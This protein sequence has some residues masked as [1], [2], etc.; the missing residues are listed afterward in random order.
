MSDIFDNFYKYASQMMST[1]SFRVIEF[2]EETSE[3]IY[4]YNIENGT[5]KP[6]V[7]IQANEGKNPAVLCAKEG[8]SIT[9]NKREDLQLYDLD[10]Y[11]MRRGYNSMLFYPLFENDKPKGAVGVYSKEKDAYDIRDLEALTTLSTYVMIAL[12]N[13]ETYTK[14]NSAQAQL[15]ESEK[16]A[17]LGGLVAGVAHE[18]NTP[19]GICVTAASRVDSKTQEFM[20]ILESG[21]MKR[22]DMTDYLEVAT[23]GNKILLTNL[24]RAADLVQ[25]FKRVAVEQSVEQKRAFNL[26]TYIE[27][28]ILSLRPELKNKPYEV[29]LDLEEIEIDSYAGAFSQVLTNFIMNSLIHGFKGKESGNIRIKTTTRNR[30]LILTYSDDGNGMT[31]E[32]LE[33]I[34]EPFFTTNRAGGGSGLGM[35]IVYNLIAQKLGGKI[36]VE[37]SVGKGVTFTIEVPLV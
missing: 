13:A 30:N 23:E 8:R 33:K 17:A 7:K 11:A 25:S 27:E 18:I 29:H 9:V 36:N 21:Q 24:K 31:P 20:K 2:E 6:L 14:L 10:E 5:K 28:T 34:Y 35:N 16:M 19:V 32:V 15:V 37:S 3:F 1:D 22:K 12:K 4:K 26:K